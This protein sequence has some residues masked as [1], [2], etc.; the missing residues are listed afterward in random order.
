MYLYT[1]RNSI[2]IALPLIHTHIS[3]T[4]IPLCIQGNLDIVVAVK[5]NS[6]E[7]SLRLIKTSQDGNDAYFI[8]VA[9]G[10]GSCS[11]NCPGHTVS[12]V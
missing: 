4:F 10:S 8:K 9:V 3:Y 2:P 11:S 1:I 7:S 5:K 6:G 12:G